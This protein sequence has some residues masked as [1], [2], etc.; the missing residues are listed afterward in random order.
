MTKVYSAPVNSFDY[1]HQ[2][3]IGHFAVQFA[4]YYETEVA[5]SKKV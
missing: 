5:A 4:R 1:L 2:N 3:G